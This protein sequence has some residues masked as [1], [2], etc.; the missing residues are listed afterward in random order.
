MLWQ[1]LHRSPFVDTFIV[2]QVSNCGYLQVL[3]LGAHIRDS[4]DMILSNSALPGSQAV[5][6][7]KP[8]RVAKSNPAPTF[9][10]AAAA[11]SRKRR[12]STS[13]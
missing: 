10:A 1:N 2:R 7:Q 11:K 13:E 3:G 4:M 12:W 8:F 5:L 9:T 6:S